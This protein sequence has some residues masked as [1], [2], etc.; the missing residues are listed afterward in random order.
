MSAFVVDSLWVVW[1]Q[2]SRT[3]R[4]RLFQVLGCWRFSDRT[5]PNSMPF[6]CTWHR[7]HDGSEDSIPTTRYC[8]LFTDS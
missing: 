1:L 6:T 5:Y 2:L 3:S 8:S 7:H 4:G